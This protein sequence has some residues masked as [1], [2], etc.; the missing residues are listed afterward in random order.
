MLN[1]IWV[2]LSSFLIILILIRIPSNDGGLAS[3]ATKSNL[4]GSPNSAEKLLNKQYLCRTEYLLSAVLSQGKQ[5]RPFLNRFSQQCILQQSHK[6]NI[7][8]L[9]PE[10]AKAGRQRV[11][12]GWQQPGNMIA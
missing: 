6:D 5:A 4:L 1:F 9:W 10:R 7:F 11:R 3:F 8:E 2:L 12:R